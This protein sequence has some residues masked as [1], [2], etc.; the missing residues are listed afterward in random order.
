MASRLE[1]DIEYLKKAFENHKGKW[2]TPEAVEKYQK[3]AAK[4]PSSDNQMTGERRELC[5]QFMKEYGVTE[6]EALNI[7]NG[8]RAYDYIAKYERIRTQTPLKIK[9]D[10]PAVS[11]NEIK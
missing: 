7:I 8:H 1:K 4:L 11:D 10:S 2:L 6:L 9:K 3:L 5:I